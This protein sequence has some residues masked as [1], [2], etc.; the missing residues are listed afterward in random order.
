MATL[1][2]LF[3][4][5]ERQS[6]RL[7]NAEFLQLPIQNHGVEIPGSLL[8]ETHQVAVL[9]TLIEVVNERFGDGKH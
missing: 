6:D 5:R 1:Y 4:V 2:K 7:L 8:I 3:P 9:S